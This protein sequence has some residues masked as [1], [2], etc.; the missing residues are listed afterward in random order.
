MS[1]SLAKEALVLINQFFFEGANFKQMSIVGYQ[2]KNW[3]EAVIELLTTRSWVRFA[4]IAALTI[5]RADA[6]NFSLTYLK[7]K[8]D[9]N[10]NG[11]P[12]ALGG[13]TG[14]G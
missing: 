1:L 11:E 2:N 9:M 7:A 6:G 10:S 8:D 5:V 13:S 14:P 12:S 3:A 4:T